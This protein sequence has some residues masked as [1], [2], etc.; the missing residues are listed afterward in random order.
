MPLLRA[1]RDKKLHDGK[2]LAAFEVLVAAA[3]VAGGSVR[4]L[5]L[6]STP[7]LLLFG[8]L[9]LRRRGIAWRDLGMTRPPRWWRPVLLGIG[10]GV[11]YQYLSLYIV[12]PLIARVTGV[13]PDVHLFAPLVGNTSYFLLSLVV[14]WT[15]AAFAE[16]LVYRG[17]VMNRVAD[18][19]GGTRAA[20]VVSLFVV[21]A[22]FGLAHLYQGT[23]GV[24]AAAL[25]G[26]VNGA[27]YLASGR[28]LWAPIIAHGVNDTVGF[29]LI[30]LG[31]Y[32]G[33]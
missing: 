8:W 27:V 6:S 21:S 12:E 15:L 31:K 5:P 30:F 2:P 3:I 1:L 11:A 16:E 10:V 28:N 29:T 14:A 25:A 4:I 20:W 17:Y 32:P 7:Y 33:L 9:M 19:A 26:L 18:L 23:S 13:L 24:T 22:L